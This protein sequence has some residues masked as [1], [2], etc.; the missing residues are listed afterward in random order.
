MTFRQLLDAALAGTMRLSAPAVLPADDLPHESRLL[1]AASFE[2]MRRLAGRRLET[3]ADLEPFDPCAPETLPEIPAAAAARL[4]RILTDRPEL[5]HEWL[6]LALV[7]AARVPHALLPDLLDHAATCDEDIQELVLQIGGERLAWLAALRGAESEWSFAAP[8]DVEECLAFGTSEQRARAL[9]SVRRHDAQRGRAWLIEALA[10]ESGG[11]R[12]M[13]LA[14]LEEGL[15]EYDEPVLE[16]ALRDSRKDV[17]LVA[18]RLIRALPNSRFGTRWAERAAQ[19]VQLNRRLTGTKLQVNEPAEVDPRWVDDG[20]DPQPPKG[21]GSKA[22]LLQ[23]VVALA[24]PRIWPISALGAFHSSEWA[25]QLLAGLG[26]AALAYGDVGWSEELLLTWA[27]AN[28]Q[29]DQVPIDA[30][31]L[32]R[33]LAAR[34]A[35]NALRR[36][37]DTAPAAVPP[38]ANWWRHVWS[39]EFSQY[40]M[41]RLPQLLR[42]WEYSATATLRPASLC[43]DPR[44]LPDAERILSG[45]PEEAWLRLSLERLVQMLEFRQALRKELV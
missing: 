13:L 40:F 18:L 12:A 17:R 30:G 14:S 26:Q 31:A 42:L 3:G 33:A 8:F 35:E 5:L 20:L 19:V 1:R 37:L 25:Q 22:W 43:L 27:K 44:V 45:Q 4:E 36:V 34:P 41:A 10:T 32:F 28:A 29:R 38:L 2:G 21:S 7:R 15:V 24:P 23:Q 11:T 9:R 16:Q 6:T 39:Q